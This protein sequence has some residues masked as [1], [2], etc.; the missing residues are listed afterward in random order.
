M[1]DAQ[2]RYWDAEQYH[3]ADELSRSNLVDYDESPGL[4]HEIYVAKTRPRPE[5]TPAMELGTFVHLA[6][7]EPEEWQGH[8]GDRERRIVCKP[9]FRGEGAKRREA[10]WRRE[11]SPLAVVV[12]P[13]E[14]RTMLERHQLVDQIAAAILEPRTP[15]AHAARRILDCSEREVTFTWRDVDPDLV[16][17]PI[18]CRAR[19]D[20]LNVTATAA[21]ITDLKTCADPT[22]RAFARA[23]V[24][25][26]YH[27]QAP[28]YGA[29]VLEVTGKVPE[30]RYIAVR[31]APPFEVV[32]YQL[33]PEDIAAADAQVRRAM[34]RLSESIHTNTWSAPWETAA[35][36]LELPRWGLELEAA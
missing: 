6:V 9:T 29:P 24:N 2:R 1:A 5:P 10:E 25:N 12:T 16:S 27:W 36:V 26:H 11:Q 4:Y 32:V 35:Q 18:H 31:S 8:R 19:L 3:G 28:F 33:R 15:A 14:R 34:R 22:P 30:F 7:L 17:G 23:V 21:R 20:L 13:R